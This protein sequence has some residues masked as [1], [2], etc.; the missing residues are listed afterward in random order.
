[1]A[2]SSNILLTSTNYFQWKSHME[3]LLRSKGLYQITL[4]KEIEPIDVDKKFKWSNKNDVARGL[5]R[6]SIYHDLRFHLQQI[7]KLDEAWENIEFVFVKHN[8]VQ[9]QQLE[10]KVLT[11]SPSDF[12]CIEDYPSKFKTLIIL[13]EECKIKMEEECFIYLIISKLGSA[14]FV[15]VST[16][17][18][19]KEAPGIA[20]Q[21]PTLDS[22][23]NALIREKYK[24][25]QLGL[26][27]TA[28]TSNKSLVAHQKDKNKNHK[29]Q[30]P[31]HNNKQHKGLKPTQTVSAP[32]GDKGE[33]Y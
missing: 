32:N 7:D 2:S 15:F 4:G 1:M 27:N 31:R 28:S 17:Y 30:H 10:N 18:D 11:L 21:K 14:H 9:A 6:I 5:I 12:S 20:Y 22:F 24:L 25:V 19:M 26:I 3:D 8:I 33:Q 13:C 29:K 23:Y 16:F